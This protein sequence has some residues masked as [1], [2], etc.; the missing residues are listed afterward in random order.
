ML[1]AGGIAAASA[2]PQQEGSQPPWFAAAAM[3]LSLGILG[4]IVADDGVLAWD[5]DA[6]PAG[7]PQAKATRG[8]FTVSPYF[9]MAPDR[10]HGVRTSSGLAGTF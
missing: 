4:A 5:E 3:G 1:T 10:D 8:P 9:S 7:A 2:G 6:G